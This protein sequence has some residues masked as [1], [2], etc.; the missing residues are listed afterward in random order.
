MLQAGAQ[1]GDRDGGERRD[2]DGHRGRVATEQQS[3]ARDDRGP[4]GQE[5]PRDQRVGGRRGQQTVDV[6]E[7][8]AQDRD[9]DRGGQAHVGQCETDEHEVGATEQEVARPAQQQSGRHEEP[10]QRQ[11][12]QLRP[13][14]PVRRAGP[15]HRGPAGGD[16]QAQQDREQGE[17]GHRQRRYGGW[18]PGAQGVRRG[19]VRRGERRGVP[20]DQQ[21]E[22]HGDGGQPG[23]DPPPPRTGQPPVREIQH[24]QRHGHVPP[25]PRALLERDEHHRVGQAR[26]PA[27]RRRVHLAAEDQAGHRADGGQQGADPVV[28]TAPH[29]QEPEHDRRQPD[30]RAG[31]EHDRVRDRRGVHQPDHPAE[32]PDDRRERTDGGPDHRRRRWRHSLASHVSRV[33]ALAPA[34]DPC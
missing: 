13:A 7:V 14:H 29:D 34:P 32:Q 10:A 18:R 23:G 3:R 2:G 26:H 28:R 24:E 21:H 17:G 5:Q 12:A 9:G 11:P 27:G 6:V 20:G 25:H 31:T 19:L 4:D 22:H 15:H 1:R 16:E 8:V 30:G 33:K